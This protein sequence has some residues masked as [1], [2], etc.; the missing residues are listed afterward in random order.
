MSF[1]L[2]TAVMAPG[3]LRMVTPP[4]LTPRGRRRDV[5][6]P[7]AASPGA[8][9]SWDSASSGKITLLSE[10]YNHSQNDPKLNL[11]IIQNSHL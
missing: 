9:A 10:D 1:I 3:V 7:A 6:S 8:S 11:S 5:W 2:T 4:S